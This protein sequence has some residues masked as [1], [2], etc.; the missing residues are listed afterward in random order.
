MKYILTSEERTELKKSKKKKKEQLFKK[1][2]DVRD[3]SQGTLENELMDEYYKRVAYTIIQ[4]SGFQD[5]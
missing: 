2:W 3:P 1:F 4:Y 5:G